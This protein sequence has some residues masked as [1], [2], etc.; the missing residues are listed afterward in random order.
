MSRRDLVQ[1][2]GG[3][4]LFAL[5]TNRELQRLAKAA[6]VVDVDA[7]TTLVLQGDHGTGVFVLLGGGARV[8][9]NKRTIAKLGAGSQFGELALL[10]PGPRTA[11]VITTEP[12]RVAIIDASTFR[13]VLHES[14]AMA[15]RLLAAL[16]RRARDAGMADSGA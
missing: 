10:D 16:A 12:S 1:R 5:C 14:P 4:P 8:V 6:E 13:A 9:R 3:V 2:L 7:D 11:T 15:E